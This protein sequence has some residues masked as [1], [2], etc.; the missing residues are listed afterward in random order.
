MERGHEVKIIVDEEDRFYATVND[1]SERRTVV[2]YDGDAS[3]T[4]TYVELDD[5][6][7]FELDF[8]D[9]G[10]DVADATSCSRRVFE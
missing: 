2:I 9:P 5:G 1:E 4:I 6:R 7:C 8:S 3:G 10:S